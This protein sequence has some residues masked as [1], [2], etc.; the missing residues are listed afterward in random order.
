[1]R[2]RER[3]A[4]AV[5]VGRRSNPRTLWRRSLKNASISMS[6][7]VVSASLVQDVEMGFGRQRLRHDLE[8][9]RAGAHHAA[10]GEA[11]GDLVDRQDLQPAL[12][13]EVVHGDDDA[14]SDGVDRPLHVVDL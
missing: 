4:T 10:G 8:L 9:R 11:P 6:F 5:K 13:A 2:A 7:L 3:T 1:P 14:G 12:G